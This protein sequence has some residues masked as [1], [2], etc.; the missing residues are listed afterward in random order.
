MNDE[1]R[2]TV[3]EF[4]LLRIAEDLHQASATAE[5][6]WD[7]AAQMKTAYDHR[8]LLRASR[9]VVDLHVPVQNRCDGCRV[10]WPCDTVRAILKAWA[11]H[12]E[13]ERWVPLDMDAAD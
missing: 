9:Q 6:A 8:A 4:I 10:V 5:G 11:D 3:R 2:L 1:V 7:N 13:T 12:P